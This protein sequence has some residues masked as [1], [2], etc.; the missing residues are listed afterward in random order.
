[1]NILRLTPSAASQYRELMLA[2]Y[3]L[4]PDAFT[5]SAAERAALPPTWW[6]ARLA[7][8]DDA[9]EIVLAA[10]D[11]EQIVGVVGLSFE[12]R[13]KLQHKAT[14]F[15]MYVPQQQRGRGLAQQL[16]QAAL[17]YLRQMRQIKLVQ[18]TVSQGNLAAEKLYTHAGFVTFGI[19]PMAVAL[20]Q[21]YA[22]KLH[23]WREV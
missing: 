8:G 22:T 10:L 21:G 14:L 15:G 5:S 13:E 9:K 18:L 19:E 16:V 7:E 2:A 12:T 6:Q 4:H 3:A 1:M 20:T 17:D 23:M 11:G